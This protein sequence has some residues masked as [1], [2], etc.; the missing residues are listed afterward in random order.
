[1]SLYNML[2]GYNPNAG[3][4]LSALQLDPRT[5]DRFRDCSLME[6][7]GK[8]VIHVFCRTGGGNRED[9]PNTKLVEHP[10]YIRDEDDDFDCTYAHYYFTLPQAVIDE[11]MAQ[12]MELSELV[13][14][15]TL[16]EKTD[17]AVD[18]LKR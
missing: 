4:L 6:V 17:R 11:V 7:D 3:K 5:I 1:M 15:E 10:L 12:G 8:V 16:K 14:N 9:Y 13:D 2:N 18:S